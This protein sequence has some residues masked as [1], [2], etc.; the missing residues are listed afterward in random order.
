MKKPYVTDMRNVL[1]GETGRP[2]AGHNDLLVVH[3][4]KGGTIYSAWRQVSDQGYAYVDPYSIHTVEGSVGEA[5]AA[6]DVL[7]KIRGGRFS[8]EK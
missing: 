6:R 4:E 7:E 8:K 3:T 1:L 2:V 5:I